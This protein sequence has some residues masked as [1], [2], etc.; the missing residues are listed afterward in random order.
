[1]KEGD[2][3]EVLPE[4]PAGEDGGGVLVGMLS[5]VVVTEDDGELLLVELLIENDAEVRVA[6][7]DD[8][9]LVLVELPIE[10]DAEELPEGLVEGLLA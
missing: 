3:A 8:A 4:G 7:W 10:T 1:M 9:E 6:I 5:G 2:G